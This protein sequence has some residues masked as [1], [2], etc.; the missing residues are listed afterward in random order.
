MH[1]FDVR[2]EIT[3]KLFET[4]IVTCFVRYM[5]AF[6]LF[7]DILGRHRSSPEILSTGCTRWMVLSR[8]K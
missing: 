8:R 4:T 1:D 5:S 7:G 3:S 2:S 6:V